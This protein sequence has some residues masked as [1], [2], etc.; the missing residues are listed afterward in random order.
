M[1]FQNLSVAISGAT[2]YV[3]VHLAQALLHRELVPK[4]IVRLNSGE[5]DISLLTLLGAQV[6][7]WDSVD[8]RSLAESLKGAQVLVHLIGSI[9][10]KKGVSLEALQ[11][12]MAERFFHAARHAGVKK[13]ILLT[14]LGSGPG[15]ESEY[16]RTKGLAE[17]ALKRSGLDYVIFRPSLIVGRTVGHRDSKI[18]RRYIELIQNKATVPL[19]LG[20][21]NK[22]QPLFIGDLVESICRVIEKNTWDR[23]ILELGGPQVLTVS[24]LVDKLMAVLQLKK[25]VK[26]VSKPLAYMAAIFCETFQEVPLVSRDQIK[27]SKIDSIVSRNALTEDFRLVPTPLDQALSCYRVIS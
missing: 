19:L 3:G 6:V 22:I 21:R 26:P 13:V 18:I 7:K 8:E 1:P 27:I 5:Q 16:H 14:A 24:E 25:P 12:G 23:S 10:P 17:E 9:A 11:T 4:C 15:A 20:G 2:G